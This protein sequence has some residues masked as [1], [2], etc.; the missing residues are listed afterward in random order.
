[1]KLLETRRRVVGTKAFVGARVLFV[2]SN[3]PFTGT[4]TS[5]SIRTYGIK[6]DTDYHVTDVFN[7]P[8][9]SEEIYI[10]KI[11]CKITD[12]ISP[13]KYNQFT[14]TFSNKVSGGVELAY[15]HLPKRTIYPWFG[16]KMKH[17][18][19]IPNKTIIKLDDGDYWYLI[20]YNTFPINMATLISMRSRDSSYRIPNWKFQKSMNGGQGKRSK[21]VSELNIDKVYSIPDAKNHMSAIELLRTKKL[22]LMYDSL[23]P[24]NA[25]ITHSFRE[26][27]DVDPKYLPKETYYDF[28]L[29]TK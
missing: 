13:I 20:A 26:Y 8:R 17:I 11:N 27:G 25:P 28:N 18:E 1:M 19:L 7:I 4:I 14:E 6:C 22:N 10:P 12:E 3:I 23:S 9:L 16:D 29:H 21:M 15:H 5:I 24:D 2:W